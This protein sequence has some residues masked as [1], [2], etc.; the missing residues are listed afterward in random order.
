MHF[1][2][3]YRNCLH[4]KDS[5]LPRIVIF[6]QSGL[7]HC[8]LQTNQWE[9]NKIFIMIHRDDYRFVEL[10]WAKWFVNDSKIL[11]LIKIWDKISWKVICQYRKL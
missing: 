10:Q 8:N 2:L 4:W 6:G 5:N 3:A 9:K 1:N 7:V 11:K